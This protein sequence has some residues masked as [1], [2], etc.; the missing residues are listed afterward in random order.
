MP[1]FKVGDVLEAAGRWSEA[2]LARALR[3]L[4]KAD[5]RLKTSVAAEVALGAAIVEA[6]GARGAA[7]GGSGSR[8]SPR[9]GR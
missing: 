9:P 8:P 1:P 5:R 4:G 2:D 3:A 7:L 6:C